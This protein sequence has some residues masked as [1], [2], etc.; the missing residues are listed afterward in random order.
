MRGREGSGRRDPG[1]PEPKPGLPRRSTSGIRPPRV[2]LLLFLLFPALGG[3]PTR[4]G[5]ETPSHQTA[6]SGPS[7]L[8]VFLSQ[9]AWG[10]S[11][12]PARLEDL[13]ARIRTRSRWLK[14]LSIEIP[15]ARITELQALPGVLSTEPV[16]RLRALRAGLHASPMRLRAGPRPVSSL[17]YPQPSDTLYGDSG[18]ILDALGVPAAHEMGFL[19]TG[20]RIGILDGHFLPDHATVRANPPLSARDFVEG[21]GIVLPGEDDPLLAAAHGTA[22]WSLVGGDLPG[23]FMGGAPQAGIVL[24]RVR[25]PDDAVTA[26]EDR[27]VEGLEW[28]E[29][30]GARIVLSGFGFREFEDSRYTL[31]DLDGDQ[32]PATQAADEAAR[33]GVLVVAPVGNG[34]PG[35]G[36]LQAPSDGDSVMAVGAGDLLGNPVGF[37]A[38]G[39][40]GD[41]REKPDIMGPGE[42][43]PAASGSDEEVLGE[44]AGTEYAG[45]LLAGAAALFIEAYPERGP[46]EVLEALRLSILPAG[47]TSPGV[48]QVAPAI[49]FP[50]GVWALPLEEVDGLGQITDLAPMF[51][52]NA[53]TLHPLG[54]P[55]TFHLQFAEDPLFQEILHQESGQGT[56]AKR[57]QEPLPPRTRLYWRVE[58]RSTQG[59]RRATAAQGPVDVP[60]WVALEVH[61]D[62]SGVQLNDPRPEFRWSALHITGPAG[63]FTFE[64]QILADRE[65]E[66]IQS[67]PG[68]QEESHRLQEPL[69]F[70]L[71]LRWRVIAQARAGAADTVTSAGP[72]VITSEEKPPVTMLYQNFPNPFPAPENGIWTTRIWFDLAETTRVELA[73]YDIRGRLVRRLIPGPGCSSTELEAGLYGRD[74]GA[75]SDP[76]L[77]FSWDGRDDRGRQAS[78][79]VYLLR[80]KA[81]GVTEIRRIV[82]W[83]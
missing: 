17:F 33:R 47:R 5:E 80:L 35:P 82:Y 31:E 10:D 11:Q 38:M 68:L 81:G 32:T 37:S 63:P 53:P 29:S 69:P 30:Q 61:N 60:S 67:H 55:V 27:W 57:V 54:L 28:L 83:P 65:G 2:L 40:T 59:V 36:T 45:A 18:P 70:N 52:W 25:S 42:G 41:G 21:D 43:V 19:G 26:D 23:V 77:S 56:F 22:L 24:A 4:Q 15:R 66:I 76:C 1:S 6:S 12:T 50:D 72:F 34:G 13:G 73:V 49:L 3:W 79:G 46:M 62:P 51:R 58:A 64:L 9:E 16:G 7:L 48:P 20:I 14:A 8:W 74:E 78:A 71:P 44:V 39:P 75:P